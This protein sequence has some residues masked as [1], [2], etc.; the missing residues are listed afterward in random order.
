MIV[1]TALICLALNIYHESRNQ[2]VAG[3]VAV[4]ETTMNRVAHKHY[5]NNVCDVVYQK[6]KKSCAFSWTCDD[7]PDKPYEKSAWEKSLGLAEMIL[8]DDYD[9][10]VVGDKVTHYHT[11]RVNP[12]WAKAK[13]LEKVR[14]IGDHIFYRWNL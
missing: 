12:Y 9:L 8:G 2:S 13:N 11:Y 3:Q 1:K 5:P 4:G 10:T 14:K 7:K 6:G